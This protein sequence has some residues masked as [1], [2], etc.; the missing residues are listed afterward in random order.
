[1]Y[2]FYVLFLVFQLCLG[3]FREFLASTVGVVWWLFSGIFGGGLCVFS[4]FFSYLCWIFGRLCFLVE[5][6]G[7]CF[8]VMYG[9]LLAEE[10]G[11][12]W[13]L[14]TKA[15]CLTAQPHLNKSQRKK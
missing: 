11:K 7:G 13:G 3:S 9:F 5:F 2:V 12:E 14:N 1:M 10:G 8:K 4:G 6:Q 15:N